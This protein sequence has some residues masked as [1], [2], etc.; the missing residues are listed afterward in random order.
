MSFHQFVPLLEQLGFSDKE[1]K[2]YFATLM[3]NHSTNTDIAEAAGMNRVTTYEILKKLKQ[4]NI[5]QSSEKS[6]VLQ[7]TAL[8]PS[9]IYSR[10]KGYV[11]A[12]QQALPE[13]ESL[14]KQNLLRPQVRFLE[15][16]SGV[17]E[18]YAITLETKGEILSIANSQNI[19]E[20][21]KNYDTE[22]VAKRAEKK[23]FL[24]GIAPRD[25]MG[26]KVH[27][28]DKKYYREIRLLEES[29]LPSSMVENE[30]CIFDNSVLIVS[31]QPDI[32]AILI[33]SPAVM[34]TQKQIFEI[35][36]N[37]ASQYNSLS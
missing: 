25:A 36:W 34:Q 29:L 22:Y 2:V 37:M 23:I 7:F 15:G 13:L 35:L 19:R 31:F 33:T 6:G 20:H 27:A 26:E 9:E 14:Q 32:F 5:V 4:R 11:E 21:W 10:S 1:A 8:S 16:I 30:I 3:K 17:K 18:G 28:D 24:R 12:F